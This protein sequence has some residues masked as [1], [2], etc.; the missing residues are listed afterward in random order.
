MGFDGH[1]IIDGDGH[2]I[3][4]Y[5]QMIRYMPKPYQEKF[6]THTFYNL[7]PPLDHLHSSNLHDFQP[8]AFNKVGPDGW[9]DF[10]EDVGIE[11]T[12]LY[13]TLGLSVGKIVSRDW[14]ID[15][16]RAYN[17]WLY[18]TYMQRSPRFK[19]MGLVPLQEPSA[20]VEELR[21]IVKEL[22]MCG[23]MLPS[24]GIQA[25][26]GD[27]RYWPI[28]EE[29]DRLGCAIGIHGGAHENMGLD[30]LTPYAPVHALGHPFGQMISFGGM[31]FN[32]VFD[33]F[34]NVKFGF[35]EGGVAWLLMCLERFDRSWETHI[36][37]D[38]RKRFLELKP[39]EKI[40][41]YI[42]RH[43]DA[44]RIFVGCEGEEPDI[45]YAIRRVG[46][47]PFVF[48]SD[49]PHEVNNE[50]CKHEISEFLEN[51]EISDSDKAAFLHGNARRF[52]NL[53]AAGL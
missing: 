40:H 49:Y 5:S 45:A 43:I 29:A 11:T 13:T 9:V 50:F 33:K 15:V 19:G 51:Q 17:D 18:H 35:M 30:D 41:E 22:G 23:A 47:K 24:T 10:L 44:G 34:P 52:Y 3:E 7:F 26:L 20:A 25:N 39:K 36:Q 37:Q 31:V 32:G 14:A 38:P 53:G 27:Q 42:Q 12:V 28:Y 1:T 4:D 8:G 16:A 6:E 48:S 21:R 2:V 46:N